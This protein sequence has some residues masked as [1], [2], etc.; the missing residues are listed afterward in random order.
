MTTSALVLIPLALLLVVLLLCFAGCGE[1]IG[2]DPWRP[3]PAPKA[4]PRVHSHHSRG[5]DAGGLLA[6]GR[7]GR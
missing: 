3:S 4:T 7:A 1:I 6:F 5:T 2:I